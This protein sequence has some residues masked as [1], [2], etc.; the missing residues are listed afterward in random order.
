[1][2]RS[3]KQYFQPQT[4]YFTRVVQKLKFPNNFPEILEFAMQTPRLGG[5][6]GSDENG[7]RGTWSV[8]LWFSVNTVFVNIGNAVA[9]SSE[10]AAGSEATAFTHSPRLKKMSADQ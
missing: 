10:A 5:T 9:A 6:K 4:A 8:T 2:P 7:S 1:M 3:I